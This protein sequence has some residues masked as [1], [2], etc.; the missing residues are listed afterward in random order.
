MANLPELVVPTIVIADDEKE[1]DNGNEKQGPPHDIPLSSVS[2]E[3][4]L[5]VKVQDCCDGQ[6]SEEPALPF[7]SLV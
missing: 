1:Y 2:D 5:P 4:L 3:V 6:E 7:S